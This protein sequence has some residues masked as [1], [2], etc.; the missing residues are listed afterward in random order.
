M[1]YFAIYIIEKN[2][3]FCEEF[4]GVKKKSFIIS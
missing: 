3:S 4:V 1:K 2:N